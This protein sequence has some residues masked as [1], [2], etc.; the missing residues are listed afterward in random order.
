MHGP[1]VPLS[2]TVTGQSAVGIGTAVGKT[3]GGPAVI[4]AT[5]AREQWSNC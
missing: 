3:I 5:G 2:T 4:A 1:T